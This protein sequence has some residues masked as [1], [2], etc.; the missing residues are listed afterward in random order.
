MLR[1]ND[2]NEI[3]KLG[4]SYITRKLDRSEKEKLAIAGIFLCMILVMIVTMILSF[5]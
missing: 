1:K 5:V 4:G 2:E 3:R